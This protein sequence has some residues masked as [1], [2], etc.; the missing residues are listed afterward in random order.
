MS[1]DEIAVMDGGKCIMRLRG[2]SPFFSDKFDIT[3]HSR[4]KEQ[5]DHDKICYWQWNVPEL[6][7]S[8]QTQSASGL[9]YLP[10]LQRRSAERKIRCV[11]CKQMWHECEP[12]DGKDAY[13]WAG[14]G[15]ACRK[16]DFVKRFKGKVR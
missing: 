12:S 16:E 2:V 7:I 15:Y 13:R 1:Q 10:E 11:L 9:A 5:S 6:R 3:K 14:K 8:G 4:Y